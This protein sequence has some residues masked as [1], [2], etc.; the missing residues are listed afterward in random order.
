MVGDFFIY[1]LFGVL[2]MGGDGGEFDYYIKGG[3]G[4]E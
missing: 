4:G 3:R 1:C 2:C